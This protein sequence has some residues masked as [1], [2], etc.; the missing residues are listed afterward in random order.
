MITD[1]EPG[2]PSC[3]N[4]FKPFTI[5]ASAAETTVWTPKTGKRFRL[6]GY[7]LY[8]DTAC[9]LIFRDNTAG[10]IILRDGVAAANRSFTGPTGKGILSATAG[11]LLTLQ[12]SVAA[13]I[14]G[15]VFGKE[16]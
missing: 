9:S 6:V 4:V 8:S 15:T 11:N 10:T 2:V 14:N 5:S 3:T 12:A 7:W 16:E 1:T 13:T